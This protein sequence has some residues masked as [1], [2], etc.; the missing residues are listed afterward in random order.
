M[1]SSFVVSRNKGKLSRLFFG[2]QN[3]CHAQ[4]CSLLRA[5][6]L[7]Q[8]LSAEGVRAGCPVASISSPML[9]LSSASNALV[10]SPSSSLASSQAESNRS[11]S[12]VYGQAPNKAGR[13]VKAG[14][15]KL[16][17]LSC[18]CMKNCSAHLVMPHPLG[19]HWGVAG[20]VLMVGATAK[21]FR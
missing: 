10:A 9:A 6:F 2:L 21:A 14:S 4:L 16:I 18:C 5:R 15:S 1:A 12:G 20:W 13:Y 19:D 11:F 17:S 8:C 3:S 7:R